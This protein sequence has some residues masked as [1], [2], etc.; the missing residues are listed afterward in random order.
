MSPHFYLKNSPLLSILSIPASTS[1]ISFTYIPSYFYYYYSYLFSHYIMYLFSL[2]CNF[3]LSM[4]S[5]CFPFMVLTFQ[6]LRI[7]LYSI[8][9]RSFSKCFPYLFSLSSFITLFEKFNFLSSL[10]LS[11]SLELV[12]IPSSMSHL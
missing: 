3:I 2:F 6:P 11:S 1:N 7:L 12:L 10:N 5:S 8:L 4:I 9:V